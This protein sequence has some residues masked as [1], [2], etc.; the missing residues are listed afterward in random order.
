MKKILLALAL[1][2]VALALP[3]PP[4]EAQ[5]QSAT[6]QATLVDGEATE[7]VLHER[8]PGGEPSSDDAWH[9]RVPV[10]PFGADT[11]AVRIVIDDRG[12]QESA[13]V[14]NGGALPLFGYH[15][16]TSFPADWRTAPTRRVPAQFLIADGFTYPSPGAPS[17]SA[18]DG[19][20]DNDGSA[21]DTWAP[22]QCSLWKSTLLTRTDH[23][24]AVAR[25]VASYPGDVGFARLQCVPRAA[26]G[27]WWATGPSGEPRGPAN[28]G[29]MWW[30]G[31]ATLRQCTVTVIYFNFVPAS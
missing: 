4:C 22:F 5:N 21:G 24:A 7:L 30:S 1:I 25:L 23:G 26:F 8:V 20:W 11:Q 16:Q 18:F 9:W 19:T 14:E 2:A 3:A 15:S 31:R 27:S 17:L 28:Y 13:G 29:H 12:R 10:S 6:F